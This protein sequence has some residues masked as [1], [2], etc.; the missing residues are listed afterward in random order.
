MSSYELAVFLQE[1]IRENGLTVTE[2][3]K[4]AKLSRES[5]Y[6]LLRGDVR[7]PSLSTLV[8]LRVVGQS[9][10]YA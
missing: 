8:R 5:V 2:V 4:R 9:W 6:K 3:A 10:S 7:E 1:T